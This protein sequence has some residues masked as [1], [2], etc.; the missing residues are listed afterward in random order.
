M[1]DVTI[2]AAATADIPTI[3]RLAHEIWW[4]AYG[5]LLSPGQISLMLENI[6]SADGL[7]Q[8]MDAGQRFSLAI[9][10]RTAV[11]FVGFRLKPSATDIMRIEKLY[12]LP[13]VQGHGIG[14]R[15]IHHVARHALAAG[16]NCLE[17]NV[18][19]YNPAKAF[20]ERQGFAVVEAVKIP[21]HGYVLDD[22][23]M[24]KKL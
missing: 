5:G 20:Y 4:P 12:I 22:Y 14:Q 24:Q 10:E 3:H 2:Q 19:R 7:Q 17:L 11:G 18:Y 15:L 6:Y 16:A 9:M 23:I 21:Y 13:A 1:N 8:Q